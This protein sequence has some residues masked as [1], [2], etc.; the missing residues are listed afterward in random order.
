MKIKIFSEKNVNKDLKEKI[1][2]AYEINKKFFED[3]LSSLFIFIVDSQENM[4]ELANLLF[5][6]NIQIKS[7][8]RGISGRGVITILSLDSKKMGEDHFE[9]T[10]TH[11]IAHQFCSK[12]FINH[13]LFYWIKESLPT[14][15]ALQN[16]PKKK[17]K[18]IPGFEEI[19][20]RK[21]WENKGFP[22]Y[23]GGYFVG[24]LIKKFG[25]ENLLEFLKELRD[26]SN[27]KFLD[28]FKKVYK[29]ELKG[30]V[31]EFRKKELIK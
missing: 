10:L 16:K 9:F 5:K 14:W 12:Y 24:F 11:E 6:K 17:L 31:N 13:N 15:I 20:T 4:R 28:I 25:K 29:K 19:C 2:K 7:W 3:E 27:E 30:L 22:Y 1:Q 18:D 21:D 23:F 26:K 8:F